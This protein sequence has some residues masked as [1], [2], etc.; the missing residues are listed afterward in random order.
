MK[1]MTILLEP[2]P[3]GSLLIDADEVISP[4]QALLIKSAG[5]D[6]VFGYLGLTTPAMLSGIMA[7]GLGFIPVSFDDHAAGWIPTA[8]MGSAEGALARQRARAL[9]LLKGISTCCDLE[10]MAGL[11]TDTIAYANSWC[12]R[13]N[14][15]GD[16]PTGYIG[17][18]VVLT[19]QQLYDLAFRGYW[20]SASE[21]PNVAVCGYQCIQAFPLGLK[22]VR[23]VT[24]PW[25]VD[26]NF[27]MSDKKNRTPIWQIAK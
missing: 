21:V 3:V 24:M 1:G 25:P 6:G 15:D 17:E 14:T 12:G 26:L 7:A 23:G 10:G 5:V 13:A 18:G 27:V 22:V 2:V 4:A 11:D 20:R 16:I 8:A 19:P 9:G